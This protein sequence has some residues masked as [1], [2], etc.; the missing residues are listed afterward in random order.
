MVCALSMHLAAGASAAC[1]GASAHCPR[2]LAAIILE[3]SRGSSSS[4]WSYP[5]LGPHRRSFFRW[6]LLFA[7]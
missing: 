5:D 2:A 3:D 1:V 4:T 6:V 7:A